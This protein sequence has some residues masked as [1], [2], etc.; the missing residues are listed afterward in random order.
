MLKTA[1]RFDLQTR[2][3][4]SIPAMTVARHSFTPCVHS[5]RIYLVGGNSEGLSEL[6]D[7]YTKEY[8]PLSL[9]VK[10]G[11]ALTVAKDNCLYVFSSYLFQ[12]WDMRD[13]KVTQ[14][15]HWLHSMLCSCPPIVGDDKVWSY[16]PYFGKVYEFTMEG[17]VQTM[18]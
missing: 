6:F 8:S 14:K 12:Q 5:S 16:N 1:E 3:W 15:Y 9:R 13:G 2:K 11:S 18:Y 10:P 17:D 7:P 4:Q